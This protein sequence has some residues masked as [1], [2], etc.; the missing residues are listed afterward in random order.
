MKRI[1]LGTLLALPFV[2]SSLPSQASAAEIIARPSV[3]KPVIVARV[4]QKF[5]P[6]YYKTVR[7]G[8]K[9]VKVRVPGHYITVRG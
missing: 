7:R 1:L 2:I 3:H 4:H 6:T 8:H 5:I 9:L